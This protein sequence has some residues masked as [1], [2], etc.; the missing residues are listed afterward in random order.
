QGAERAGPSHSSSRRS[1]GR[2]ATSV[3]SRSS[4]SAASTERPSAARWKPLSSI[5]RLRLRPCATPRTAFKPHSAGMAPELNDALVET[6]HDV[7]RTVDHCALDSTLTNLS[8]EG[9]AL[10]LADVFQEVDQLGLR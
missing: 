4:R 8:S 5:R 9:I 2:R 10:E 7:R 1:P 3:T 6:A